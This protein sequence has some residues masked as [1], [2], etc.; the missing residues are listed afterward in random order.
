MP[1][2]NI[3]IHPPW[4]AHVELHFLDLQLE[5]FCRNPLD[6]NVGKITKTQT[7]IEKMSKGTLTIVELVKNETIQ[8]K[9]T[10]Y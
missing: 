1:D 2:I 3:F 5:P 4:T 10:F 8:W 9:Q 7:R 6:T